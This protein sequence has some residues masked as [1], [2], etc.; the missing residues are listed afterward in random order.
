MNNVI[1]QIFAFET[2]GEVN[3]EAPLVARHLDRT[4]PVFYM[5]RSP[6]FKS[7][8]FFAPSKSGHLSEH[9]VVHNFSDEAPDVVREPYPIGVRDKGNGSVRQILE[10]NRHT[11]LF[12]EVE[13]ILVEDVR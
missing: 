8:K 1:L 4:A 3:K 6:Q 11:I 7:V 5:Q 12:N 9:S 13:D 10:R 2:L